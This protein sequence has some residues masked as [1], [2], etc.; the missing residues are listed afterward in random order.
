[1][2]KQQ[3]GFTLIELV[4]VIVI[5]GILAAVAVP[6]LQGMD[7]EAKKA[8]VQGELSAVQSAAVISFAKKKSPD[9]YLNITGTNTVMDGKV[10]LLGTNYS[11]NT[12]CN[13][14]GTTDTI[15]YAMYFDDTSATTPPGVLP[16]NA[17]TLMTV[18]LPAGLC[19]N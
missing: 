9:T 6:K 11:P 15:V 13:P 4:V 12:K 18:T 14:D 5:L 1:M 17:L 10:T 19:A 16:S 3:A 7:I 8:V 2:K